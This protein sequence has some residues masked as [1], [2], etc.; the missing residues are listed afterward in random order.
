M[1]RCAFADEVVA[2][3]ERVTG[4]PARLVGVVTAGHTFL[5]VRTPDGDLAVKLTLVSEG[6]PDDPS[7][8]VAA[9]VPGIVPLLPDHVASGTT[10]GHA[11]VASR[12]T[13]S[14][15]LA[16]S[17]WWRRTPRQ[18]DAARRVVDE[19]AAVRTGRRPPGGRPA[20]ST[21]P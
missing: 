20:G 7:G 8:P 11:W 2:D 12:W 14:G 6:R 19:L 13:P 4:V 3:V 9:E 21:Q 15:R 1:T 16:G 10:H 5:R 17:T 18:R